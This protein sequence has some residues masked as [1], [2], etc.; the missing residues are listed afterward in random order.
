MTQQ[1]TLKDAVDLA[2]L[3]RIL[4]IKLRHHGDVLLSTPVFSVLKQ[5]APQLSVDALVYADTREMLSGHPAI[6]QLFVIDR[7]WRDYGM[8]DKTQ[9]EWTLLRQLAARRYD[10]IIHLTTHKRGMWLAWLL[11]PRY[12]IGYQ[13]Q[14]SGAWLWQ[15]TFTHLVPIPGKQRHTVEKHLDTLR[16]IGLQPDQTSRALTLVPGQDAEDRADALLAPLHGKPFLHCHPTSRWLFKCWPAEK[17]AAVL[18]RLLAN[19]VPIVLTA[20]PSDT[21]LALVAQIKARLT[22]PIVDLSGQLS[23]KELAA[24][25][26][27]AKCF[28]GVD[29]APMH[30]AAAVKTPVVALFG[31]SGDQEW[32]P[33]Q[34]E[35]TIITSDHSCR[36]CGLDGCGSGKVSECLSQLDETRVV[37]ALTRHLGA[38]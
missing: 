28:F 34:T 20:A 18:N 33:W 32:A 9:R 24:V 38:I 29:S 4:V 19:N 21:E 36:P 1:T 25:C 27:R 31:P 3:Q 12:S 22:K 16:R 35:H 37:A 17:T 23:L 26:A 14:R 5:Q 15:R 30:I 8:W 2:Q 13:G 6:E 7:A 10:A 11:Q